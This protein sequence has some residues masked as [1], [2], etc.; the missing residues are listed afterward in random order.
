M[1][2]SNGVAIG[3]AVRVGS[4]SKLSVHFREPEAVQSG[5][6]TVCHW[7]A[8]TE[9]QHCSIGQVKASRAS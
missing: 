3:Y 8:V 5:L 6:H 4:A 2:I 7:E 1:H 9:S